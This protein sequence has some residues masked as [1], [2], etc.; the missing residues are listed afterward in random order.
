MNF[1]EIDIEE[2]IEQT[3]KLAEKH[4]GMNTR[5]IKL[6][7]IKVDSRGKF[8]LYTKEKKEIYQF[9]SIYDTDDYVDEYTEW[10]RQHRSNVREAESMV[11]H[12]TSHRS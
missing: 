11:I 12:G 9:G 1:K 3:R 7:G 5:A 8:E 6:Q 4:R 2:W 10:E